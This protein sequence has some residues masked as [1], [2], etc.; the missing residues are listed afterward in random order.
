MADT[1]RKLT[2]ADLAAFTETL[3]WRRKVVHWAQKHFPGEAW[4]AT[5]CKRDLWRA[6]GVLESAARA[7]RTASSYPKH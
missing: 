5:G 1:P 3:E 6:A 2:E 4:V 7:V